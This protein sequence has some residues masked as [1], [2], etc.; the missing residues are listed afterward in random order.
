MTTPFNVTASM[1]RSYKTC[2]R[3]YEI[4]YV[5]LL[6]P[7][8]LPDYFTIGTDYH[9]CI[10]RLL[11]GEPYEAKDRVVGIMADSFDRHIPWREWNIAEAEKEFSV[12]IGYNLWLRGKIDAILDDGTPLEHKTAGQT[13][14]EKYINHLAWDDQ[15]SAYMLALT[16]LGDKP[17]TR[18]LYTVCQKPTIKQT[19]KETEEEYFTRLVSWYDETKTRCLTVTRSLGE[20]RE[21]H[22]NIKRIAYEMRRRKSGEFYRN[23]SACALQGCIYS[24]ICL[25]YDPDI[26]MGFTKKER[27]SVSIHAPD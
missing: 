21:T 1:I 25:N 9:A 20:L 19:Q 23:P 4:E 15:A 16:L 2:P 11:R 17:V 12:H 26:T 7:A 6:K 14:G 13:I 5:E 22:T 8:H 10:E 18:L 24:P 27:T 3:K